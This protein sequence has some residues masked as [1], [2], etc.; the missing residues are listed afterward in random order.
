MDQTFLAF[1][2]LQAFWRTEPAEGGAAAPAEG[3]M[4]D[5][6]LSSTTVLKNRF[7]DAE[8]KRSALGANEAA[9]VS[10]SMC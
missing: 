2:A 8:V 6:N 5:P 4:V 1:V 3:R 10:D 7:L 9:I